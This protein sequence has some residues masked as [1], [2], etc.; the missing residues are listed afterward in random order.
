[1]L[2]TRLASLL[3]IRAGEGRLVALL[4]ALRLAPSIGAAI[5]SPGV[6]AL[7]YARFGVEFLPYMYISL[8]A[9]TIITSMLITA[10]LGRISKK[11]LYLT[12][13][14]ILTGALVIAR[15]LVGLDLN[16]FYPVLWLGMYLMWTLQALLT[17][18]MA[19]EIFD[20]R[21]AKRLFPLLGAGGIL[22]IAIGG[23]VT[24]PLVRLM[25]TENLLLVWGGTL[26]V[27]FGLVTV[28]S[29]DM[30]ETHA[31]LPSWRKPPSLTEELQRGYQFV[32]RSELMR[33]ISIA[34]LLFMV[35]FFALGFPFSKAVAAEFPDE[36]AIAGFL[37]IFQGV[38]T[39]IAFLVSMLLANR[40]YA[41]FGFMGVIFAL[42]VIYLVG[43]SILAA[44]ALFTALIVFRFAQ[45]TWRLGVSET[46][47]QAVFNIV[48]SERR[49]QVRTFINGIPAQLGVMLVGVI[50]AIGQQTLQP[51]HL[52]L[53]GVGAA[54]L[55]TAVVWRA[56]RAYR[57]ALIEALR[58][59]QPHV[60][61]SEE[62]P[63]GGFQRDAAAAEAVAKGLS[64]PDPAVRRVST[65]ILGNLSA[66][67][68]TG[69]L[70]KR[71]ND[72]DLEV[73][74]AALRALER[75]D[76][77]KAI[78]EVAAQLRDPEPDVRLQ[79]VTTLSHLAEFSQ[80]LRAHLHPM[81]KDPAPSV[82]AQAAVVLLKIERDKQAETVL[83]NLAREKAPEQRILAL[84]TLAETDLE[85]AYDLA[86]EALEDTNPSVRFAAA[87]AIRQVDPERCLNQLVQTLGDEDR[88]VREGVAE[89]I[90]SIGERALKPTLN[91][92]YDPKKEDGALLTLEQLPVRTEADSIR[93]YAQN[94]VDSALRYHR[95]WAM[96]RRD[97]ENGVEETLALLAESLRDKALSHADFA[98][99]AV[100][101][102][103][104]RAAIALARENLAS[105]NPNQRANALETLDSVR[106][107]DLIRP[108][109]QLWESESSEVPVED[110]WVQSL[111][112]DPDPWLR[113]CAVVVARSVEDPKTVAKLIELEQNDPDPFVRQT[114]REINLPIPTRSQAGGFIMD[115][116]PT[117]SIMERIL[118]L[119]AVPL[120]TELS[121][122]ELKQV[123]SI[124]GEHYFVDGDVIAK[125]GEPGDEMYI[126]I[127]GEVEVLVDEDE[128]HKVELARRKPGE[129]VGEMAIIS[130]EP[131]MASLVARGDVRILCIEQKQFE[132]ILRERP[133][134]SLAVM[135][136][137]ISR[138]KEGQGHEA[139]KEP[140]VE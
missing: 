118:S 109:I 16:W 128:G 2:R 103:G 136:V 51:Q 112:D 80:G 43:F 98:L 106:E 116:L 70:V 123:A 127:S 132:S 57:G 86:V 129:Y 85:Y 90:G 30:G 62:E 114:V 37:G 23:L 9:I 113:V 126:I 75:A 137:L 117:M 58:A 36:D 27:V 19:G 52:Y 130:Q 82:R 20:T 10:M 7:F 61:F 13:P 25:G 32:R 40:L 88:Y 26:V 134:T 4:F 115:T 95:H 35:L 105:A 92:L 133:E 55:T 77:A 81:L 69:E 76:A 124:A 108:L 47:Y 84:K 56:R 42:P 29:S 17:W 60:F 93:K 79:A 125:Q 63:F 83:V 21:Q 131:R 65:E 18:G 3:Q 121:P 135:R 99:R 94:R 46:A 111:L 110:D 67:E 139:Q 87:Q 28:L 5:G 1:M 31:H 12:L 140:G 33:W 38:T 96:A 107:R 68:M 8:G 6:E 120:F 101:L 14:L 49:E 122:A 78:L 64:D 102:L 22:G 53:I 59:G 138:L 34:A 45:T 24:Q 44:Y 91:A 50:L 48:P 119:R 71:L 41:R 89:A 72:D 11:R 100:G 97:S 66:P 74:C 54:V 104:D 73:R 39:G 15:I